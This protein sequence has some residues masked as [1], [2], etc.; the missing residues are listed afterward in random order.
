MKKLCFVLLI[1][2]IIAGCSNSK[3]DQLNI[4]EWMFDNTLS[5]NDITEKIGDP[6]IK[7]RNSIIYNN[8]S[9]CNDITGTLAFEHQNGDQ[10]VPDF[11]HW[12]FTFEPNE[13]QFEELHG[14]LESNYHESNF[15]ESKFPDGTIQCNFYTPYKSPYNDG[16]T[17]TIC[18]INDDDT[19]QVVWGS[20]TGFLPKSDQ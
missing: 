15:H 7:L 20:T 4:T 8:W 13:K 18:L 3:P 12:V 9:I 19:I 16:T 2:P 14:I 17:Y 11:S 10:Y 5:I 6:D 1:V